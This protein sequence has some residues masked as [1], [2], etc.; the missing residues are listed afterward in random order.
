MRITLPHY[1]MPSWN[2]LYAG[3]HWTVRQEMANY[4]HQSVMEA[5][6]GL[7]W[8]QYKERVNI[9]IT[10]YLKRTIDPSNVCG[11]LVEDGLKMAG[12]I[13]DDTTFYI[14]QFATR[15]VKAKEDYTVIEIE[16]YV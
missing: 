10:A 2:T 8:K 5:L 4:A 16:E 14:H 13:K 12:V 9:T 1:K 3:K 15:V 6:Q 11:K 7:K